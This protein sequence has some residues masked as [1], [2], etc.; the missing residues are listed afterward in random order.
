MS[1]VSSSGQGGETVRSAN[2]RLQQMLISKH[3][4]QQNVNTCFLCERKPF[5]FL[6]CN[7]VD[8][9][10]NPG[11]FECILNVESPWGIYSG[12]WLDPVNS[13]ILG[14]DLG[15]MYLVLAQSSHMFPLY[16]VSHGCRSGIN[17]SNIYSKKYLDHVDSLQC[18]NINQHKTINVITI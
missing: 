16:H 1:S 6:L 7:Q 18:C 15:R 5:F 9:V 11:S 13:I 4:I 3:Q 17:L 8:I 14:R 2:L 10:N 12:E